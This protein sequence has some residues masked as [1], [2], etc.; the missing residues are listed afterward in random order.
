ML[1]SLFLV[2]L[3][4]S[5]VMIGCS[6]DDDNNVITPPAGEVL[7]ATV[8]GDSVGVSSGFS[9]RSSSIGSSSLN[10]TDRSNIRISFDYSGENN[11]TPVPFQI[12]YTVDTTDIIVYNGNNLPIST[13][14]KSLDTTFASPNVN[15]F[16]K[17]KITTSSAPG[18]SY[19]EFKNLK[20]YKK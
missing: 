5:A 12:Y 13:T 20:V 7:L 3:L 10:F 8:S 17:Y 15:Q 4:S 18:F 14:V 9:S 16:F 6:N 2:L 1:K 19:F 11:N